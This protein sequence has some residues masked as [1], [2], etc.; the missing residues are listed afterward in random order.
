MRKTTTIA[1]LV[2][3]TVFTTPAV[4]AEEHGWHAGVGI[5]STRVDFNRGFE[6]D[7]VSYSVFGG[8]RFNRYF[9]AELAYLD[10]GKAHGPRV[11]TRATVHTTGA[12]A[13]GIAE[14]P[15][16]DRF[17]VFGRLG[18]IAWEWE[19]VGVGDDGIDPH[20]GI[21]S[22]FSLGQAQ[23]RLEVN[24]ADLGGD[25]LLLQLMLGGVWRF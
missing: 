10:G 3:L 17:S 25:P 23:L 20:Y 7:D 1:I 6:G 8:Y 4:A 14:L 16:G 11:Q 21:G 19:S 9:A 12:I 22:G 13:S 2:T 5:G 24:Y 15:L 18:A